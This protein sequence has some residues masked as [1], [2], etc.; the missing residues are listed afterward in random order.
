MLQLLLP[1]LSAFLFGQALEMPVYALPL[2]RL[3]LRGGR[4]WLHAFAPTGLT[5][6]IVWFVFPQLLPMSYL[7]M[8]IAAE[9]FAVVSEAI[10]L[11]VVGVRR[12]LGWSLLANGLSCGGALASRALFG[13]P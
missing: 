7:V 8:C 6:P 1:W 12:P 10:Y 13:W 5:H 4:L 9:T 2:R 11:R 3:G